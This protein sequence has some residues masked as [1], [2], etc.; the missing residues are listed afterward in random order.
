MPKIFAY[1]GYQGLTMSKKDHSL[2]ESVVGK[3]KVAD[4]SWIFRIDHDNVQ[5]GS[6]ILI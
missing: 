3:Y 4:L 2:Y 6:L 1:P 5:G